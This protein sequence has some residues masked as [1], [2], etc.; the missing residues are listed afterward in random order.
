MFYTNVKVPNE[1]DGRGA[2]EILHVFLRVQLN[3]T[4]SEDILGGQTFGKRLQL[5][6]L[7][8]ERVLEDD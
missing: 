3:K 5:Y 4:G 8:K 2:S 7:V 6:Y 1:S